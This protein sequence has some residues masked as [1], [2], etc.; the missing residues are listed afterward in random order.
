LFHHRGEPGRGID[1]VYRTDTVDVAPV[2]EF[3]GHRRLLRGFFDRHSH[4]LD[5]ELLARAQLAPHDALQGRAVGL[6]EIPDV[7]NDG[8]H[9]RSVPRTD[10]RDEMTRSKARRN[11]CDIGRI[12]TA[13]KARRGRYQIPL[14]HLVP[15][16]RLGIAC[17][18]LWGIVRLGYVRRWSGPG[19]EGRYSSAH[20]AVGQTLR[21]I[22]A[23]EIRCHHWMGP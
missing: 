13:V 19:D 2:R 17:M 22:R 1:G 14:L 5:H 4:H 6:I 9:T 10:R 20:G 23:V 3:T 11:A 7:A 16:Q 15:V 8:F 18:Q 21:C 12:S